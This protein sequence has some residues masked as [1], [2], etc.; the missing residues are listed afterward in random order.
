MIEDRA[1]D[2]R[3]DALAD[4]GDEI[5]PGEGGARQNHDD[6]D[7]DLQGRIQ[8][9]HAALAKALI[10]HEPQALAQGEH[11][12]GRHDQRRAC[13]AHGRQIGF[14]IGPDRPQYLDIAASFPVLVDGAVHVTAMTH[15]K[16]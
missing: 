1:A 5:E 11:G 2:I 10:D 4:P 14:Q 7:Q 8:H 9:V 13:A 3:D 12:S 15:S 16:S 6:D